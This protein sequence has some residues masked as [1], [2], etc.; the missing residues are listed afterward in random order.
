[1]SLDELSAAV[2]ELVGVLFEDILRLCGLID[3]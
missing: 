1:M 3:D 2:W